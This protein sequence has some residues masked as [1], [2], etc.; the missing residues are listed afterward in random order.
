LIYQRY[1][2]RNKWSAKKQMLITKKEE[3]QS[4][5]KAKPGLKKLIEMKT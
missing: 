4:I 2:R 5:I 3:I 1:E